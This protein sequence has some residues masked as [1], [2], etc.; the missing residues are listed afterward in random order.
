MLIHVKGS[1]KSVRKLV[2]LA[3]WY[4]AEKLMGRRSIANLEIN[5][6]LR[7]DMLKK[8]NNEGTAIWEDD[9]RTA[10]HK[11]FLIEL[12]CSVKI[13]N[14]LISLAHEMVHIK[15]W[16]KNEMYEY[17]KRD[18]VRFHSTKFNLSKIDYWD[19]P[20]EIEAFAR[21]L[22]LFVR[23]CEENGFANRKDMVEEI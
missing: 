19:Y 13:R 14:L 22:C 2:R 4:Y 5:I 9:W 12:D 17:C 20:W 3:A 16:A 8:E 6:N 11:E 10:P 15:Q 21:Q 23:F 7:K 1:N 18:E